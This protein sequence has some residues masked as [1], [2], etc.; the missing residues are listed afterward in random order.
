ML[1]LLSMYVFVGGWSPA[2]PTAESDV[3]LPQFGR[4][5]HVQGKLTG[6]E[7][8]VN[9]QFQT[10]IH[11]G[12]E[13]GI[14]SPSPIKQVSLFR[15]VDGQKEAVSWTSQKNYALP[16]TH[17]VLYE[18]A[19]IE[20]GQYEVKLSGDNAADYVCMLGLVP[21]SW[22][23]DLPREVDEI[24][25][26][27][28]KKKEP[29]I[30]WTWYIVCGSSVILLVC[31]V[32]CYMMMSKGR[33]SINSD[34]CLQDDEGDI[35]SL[36]HDDERRVQVSH[37][38]SSAVCMPRQHPAC[39]PDSVGADA[40]VK[41]SCAGHVDYVYL[42]L[43][44]LMGGRPIRIGR[45]FECDI[46][47]HNAKVSSLHCELFEANGRLMLRDVNSRNGTRVNGRSLRPGF[48]LALLLNDV[49]SISEIT[50]TI[51]RK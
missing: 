34:I 5:I 21:C 19:S 7:E 36:P 30:D 4:T 41:I 12:I 29:S 23:K 11:A 6:G 1:T 31:M 33:T 2:L 9:H 13:V 27:V 38:S 16:D 42:S 46:V 37:A 43:R 48:A 3:L 44:K 35:Q 24:A 17:G 15:V 47:L 18:A 39:L 32:G 50:L 49:V 20:P 14:I 8:M 22:N 40:C 25:P 51:L 10:E 26:V 28:V 45:S